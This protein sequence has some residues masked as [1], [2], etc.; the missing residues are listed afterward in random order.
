[1]NPALNAVDNDLAIHQL[2]LVEFGPTRNVQSIA[3]SRAVII[4][5][6]VRRV[7]RPDV[8]RGGTRRHFDLGF[9]QA[10]FGITDFDSVQLNF[11]LVPSGDGDRPIKVTDADTAIGTH[12]VRLVEF[13]SYFG[14]RRHSR[15]GQDYAE[16]DYPKSSLSTDWHIALLR[17]PIRRSRG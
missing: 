17:C 4:V 11:V 1:M 7:M 8:D 3:D 6:S 10:R 9:V 13:L 15:R 14:Q 2:D 16:E 12:C 5:Q